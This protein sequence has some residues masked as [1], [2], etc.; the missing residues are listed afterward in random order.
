MNNAG[1]EN[2]FLFNGN[3]LT[4]DGRDTVATGLL[5]E[6]G[7]I[8]SVAAADE[9]LKAGYRTVD[10]EGATVLPGFIDPHAHP[11]SL[12]SALRAIDC[13]PPAVTSIAGIV[14]RI[15][16]VAGDPERSSEAWIRARG[17]DELRLAEGRHPTATDLDNAAPG[18]CVRLSHEGGHGDVLSTAAMNAVGINRD[19]TPPPGTTIERDPATGDPTGV[20]F[21]MGGWLRDRMP[22]PSNDALGDYAAAASRALAAAGVTAVTDAGRDN[23]SDRLSLYAELIA[24][25]SFT[26]RPTVMLSADSDYPDP[27]STPGVRAGATKIAITFSSGQMHPDFDDLVAL[28]SAAHRIG[29]QVAVHAIEI[30]AVVMACQAFRA[31]GPRDQIANLRHRIEHAS[32][33]PPEIA[34]MVADNGLSVVTQPGFIHDRA[35]RYLNAQSDGGADPRHLYA[36]QNLLAARVPVAGSSDAPFGPTSPLIGIQ[37]AVT[38]ASSGGQQIGP[39][40]AISVGEALRLYGP[41]AAWLDHQ[42]AEAGSLESGKRADLVVIERDPHKI[43]PKEIGAISVLATVIG[44][45]LVYGSLPG[46]PGN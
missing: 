30:E 42:E 44:G 17:Y 3:V 4:L 13:S 8:T 10:L 35:D 23:T 34:E 24:K 15:T 6:G 46:H 20:L 25:A 38:R 12:G 37:T 19:S 43:D 33:C 31:V 36:I 18:R 29:R 40:Q 9:R 1:P 26:P 7:R 14:R 22:S 5:I 32:E 16:E 41:G 45:E 11:L 2:A 27:E 39:E 21:E 28:I